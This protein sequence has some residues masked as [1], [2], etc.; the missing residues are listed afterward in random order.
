MD[1]NSTRDVGVSKTLSV[2]KLE[3]VPS[4]AIPPTQAKTGLAWATHRTIPLYDSNFFWTSV[5]LRLMR[6]KSYIWAVG[7]FLVA[8]VLYF[9]GRT[10]HSTVG[11]TNSASHHRFP[12][13]TSNLQF[14]AKFC[15]SSFMDVPMLY[16][17]TPYGLNFV[18]V[19]LG[20]L[21]T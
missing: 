10:N 5:K 4:V 6:R 13:H 7:A 1:A 12:K 16:C 15:Y 20:D 9:H 17:R 19:G 21:Q 11:D 8:T 14:Y 18:L 3:N 2:R